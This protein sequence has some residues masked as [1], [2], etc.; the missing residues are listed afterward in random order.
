MHDIEI[1]LGKRSKLYRFFEILP[2][3]LS[4]SLLLLPIILAV[5]NPLLAAIFIIVYTISWI[6]R[7]LVLAVRTLQGYSIMRVAEDIDWQARLNDLSDPARALGQAADDG[8]KPQY[9]AAHLANL[10][11]LSGQR[12]PLPSEI[13]Q[14]VII[15]TYNEAREVLEPTVQSVLS[16]SFPAKQTI[17]VIGYEARGPEATRATARELADQYREHFYAAFAFEHPSDLPNEV[18]G[19]G[20]N[21]V[22]AGRQ[23][24]AWMEKRG[25]NK[26][27]V[28]I[29]TLDSDNRPH[30]SYLSYL[31][32]EFIV[33]E[34]R[35]ECAYQPIA[36][37]LNNIWDVP[38]PMRV[39]ATGNSFWNMVNSLRPH[40]LRNFAAHAQSLV[41]LEKTDFW[42][43]RTVV[44]D[45]HQ[46]WRS[47]FAFKGQYEVI[48]IYVPIYQDAVLSS[49]YVKTLKA[50]FIQLRRWAYGASD[51]PYV[52][53]RVFSR[54]REVPLLDGFFKFLRLLDGHVS[55]ATSSIILA[56]GAWAPLVFA[57]ESNRSIVAHELPDL[58]SYLQW[59][60]YIGLVLS[61]FLSMKMLPPR[62]ARYKRRRNLWMILQWALMPVTSILYGSSAAIYSQTRLLL[63][64]YLDK[65]DVTDKSVVSQSG[66]GRVQ[67]T[68][69]HE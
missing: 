45:G 35:H 52:A 22:Y 57:N 53:T 40:M 67:H 37:F 46:F 32:Y 47:Y 4:L 11:R 29:T 54:H 58:V 65:F 41:S 64:K 10:K 3:L 13:I 51:V 44:E 69:S 17:L 49:T 6:I 5:F 42:S 28:I 43:T 55:W 27:H 21:I 30:P 33:N 7:A 66:S 36:L 8:G 31:A 60:G 12:Y 50:Q 56:F 68:A 9:R 59:L 14:V 48:P 2:G 19:K 18:V 24:Q 23:L 26:E 61:I 38:A 62:P 63:G 34:R 16:N 1:P 39:L 25:V 15:A 20:G